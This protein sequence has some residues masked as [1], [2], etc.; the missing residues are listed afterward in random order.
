[1]AEENLAD[2]VAVNQSALLGYDGRK[3][4]SQVISQKDSVKTILFAFA[5]GQELKTHTA[6][7]EVIVV[8]V[9]GQALFTLGS[10]EFI[11]KPG[12]VLKIPANA[13]HAVKAKT[14]FKMLL[15]K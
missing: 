3:L 11:I 7:V 12:D 13:Q 14:D 5:S 2:A 8:P 4:Q 1:M 6:P 9:E 15:I 10:E